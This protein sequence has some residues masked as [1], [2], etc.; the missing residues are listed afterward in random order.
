MVLLVGGGRGKRDVDPHGVPGAGNEIGQK[1]VL[2]E[3]FLEQV[4]LEYPA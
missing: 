3:G 4:G 1:A 2:A